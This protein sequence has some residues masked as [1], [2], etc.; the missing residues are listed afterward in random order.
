VLLMANKHT[1]TSTLP[2]LAVTILNL[3]LVEVEH[4]NPITVGTANHATIMD[5]RITS[6]GKEF[7]SRL[8]ITDAVPV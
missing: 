4:P 7:I 2:C 5:F 6:H 8:K 3:G 1:V